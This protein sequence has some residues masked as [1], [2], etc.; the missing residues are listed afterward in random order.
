MSDDT[1]AFDGFDVRVDLDRWPA[2]ILRALLRR[3]YEKHELRLVSRLLK[4]QDRVVE[5]GCAIGVVA[6][7]ASRIVPPEQIFCF[8]ANPDMVAEAARNFERNGKAVSVENTILTAGPDETGEVTFYKTPYFLS[9]SLKPRSADAE[10][11]TVPAVSLDNVIATRSANVLIV[12][13]EGGEFGLLD[14]ADLSMIDTLI[15]ELHVSLA[16]VPACLHL[17]SALEDRGLVLDVDLV[18][19]NVFVFARGTEQ[20]L[21]ASHRHEF[22][23]A[24]LKGLE[25]SEAGDL[26]AAATQLE[27]AC[28]VNV[29]NAHAHLLLSQIQFS[30]GYPESAL[31]L[32]ETAV[33]LDPRNEDALEQLAVLLSVQGRPDKAAD[34]YGGAIALAPHRPLFHASLGTVHAR[35]GNAE[36]A[37]NAFAAA[38][39]LIP[40][41]WT[42]LDTLFH[43]AGRQDKF[44]GDQGGWQT[45][46]LVLDADPDTVLHAVAEVL[47]KQFRFPD[48]GA[49]LDRALRLAPADLPLHVGLAVLVARPQDLRRAFEHMTRNP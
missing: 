10:P 15:L 8:D 45:T 37:L 32:A 41:R 47:R 12:D 13:I 5:L 17:I 9:S 43:L 26:D 4:P 48:A 22:A 40:K 29:H 14:Q 42:S 30:G 20:A 11:V 23:Q 18:A 19:H 3:H 24:Y 21:S 6:L 34:V 28:K 7:A 46:D 31:A 44:A 27:R 16:D 2:K 49:A 25:A 36:P 38:V 39:D 1:I 33:R 35:L